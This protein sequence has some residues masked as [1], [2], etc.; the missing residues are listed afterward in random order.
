MKII[1]VFPRR[2]S[3]TPVDDMAFVGNP[4][5]LRPEADEEVQPEKSRAEQRHGAA[6]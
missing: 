5:M 6:K 4:P 2:T 1:R 3:L